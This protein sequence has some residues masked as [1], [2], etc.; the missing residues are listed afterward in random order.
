MGL[1]ASAD[2]WW[3]AAGSLG[4]VVLVLFGM[5]ITAAATIYQQYRR[6]TVTSRDVGLLAEIL[7]ELD[8]DLDKGT[9]RSL[10]HMKKRHLR[11]GNGK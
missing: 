10:G 11:N 8:L 3:N 4:M 7:L 9:K 5:L 6:Q 2:G 1:I